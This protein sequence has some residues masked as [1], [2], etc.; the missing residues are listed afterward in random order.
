VLAVFDN[1]LPIGA[2]VLDPFAGSNRI[3]ELGETLFARTTVGVELEPEWAGGHPRTIHGDAAA[4]PFPGASFDAVATSPS[5]GNRY[6]DQ[7]VRP[8]ATTF[9]Y[10]H[11]LGRRC[12]PGSGAALQ[13]GPAYRDLHRRC[14]VEMVRV[15]RPGALV[16]V[17]MKDHVRG[18]RRQHVVDWW[19]DVLQAEGLELVDRVE[20]GATR[21]NG[22]VL[23]PSSDNEVVIVAE[24]RGP[25]FGAGPRPPF[26]SRSSATSPPTSTPTS[27]DGPRGR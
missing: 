14:V 9:S 12:S 24:R 27:P 25:V 6:A 3:H 22:F 15:V 1:L 13:W 23:H 10:A 21:G 26:D 16:L 11:A 5:Y 7:S 20:I 19:V 2:R 8:E 17:N 4:L 18:G